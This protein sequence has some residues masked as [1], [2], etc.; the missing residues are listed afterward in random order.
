MFFTHSIYFLPRALMN[1][2]ILILIIVLGLPGCKDPVKEIENV[3]EEDDIRT[4]KKITS[5]SAH[6]TSDNIGIE[7]DIDHR[8]SIA[9][10]S[11]KAK[12]EYL[13]FSIRLIGSAGEKNNFTSW[14]TIEVSKSVGDSLQLYVNDSAKRLVPKPCEGIINLSIFNDDICGYNYS[15]DPEN[16]TYEPL[17]VKVNF[18]R[19]NGEI[20]SAV[21]DVPAPLQLI[22]PRIPFP[23]IAYTDTTLLSWQSEL[24]VG[25]KSTSWFCGALSK[26]VEAGAQDTDYIISSDSFLSESS[27]SP[28]KL[29]MSLVVFKEWDEL[30]GSTFKSVNISWYDTLRI[31]LFGEYREGVIY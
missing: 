26:T 29:A 2:I 13:Q 14:Q 8:K 23:P 21:F 28:T 1:K 12:E 4:D 18:T 16:I 11:I 20:L 19:G 9:H 25:L 30:Q 31:L 24:P 17:H 6:Y 7:I 27:C 5:Q 22:E 15:F 10:S 3:I